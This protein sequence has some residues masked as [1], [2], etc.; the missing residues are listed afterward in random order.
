MRRHLCTISVLVAA[1]GIAG[2]GSHRPENA[3]AA[4]DR[5]RQPAPDGEPVYEANLTVQQDGSHGPEAC[6]VSTLMMPPSCGGLPIVGW[7]WDEVDGEQTFGPAT[8][9]SYHLT[10][11]YDDGVF[12]LTEP[13]GPPELD[14]VGTDVAI[15]PACDN[16]EVVDPTQS[17]V[18]WGTVD[19]S[20]PDLVATWVD[21]RP[22]G[23]TDGP[24]TANVV[25][26]RSAGPTAAACASSSGRH[27]PWTSC[28]GSRTRSSTPTRSPTTTCPSR[29][30]PALSSTPSG[31][32]S[33]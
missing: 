17:I 29:P 1:L 21:D 7:D 3:G 15:P 22:P 28:A 4:R 12:T 13:A 33:G 14:A 11:R 8:W 9:G 16:P 6:V 25:V 26:L 18:R 2:C 30:A 5:A 23:V 24:F 31:W 10:G 19:V 32:R 20:G 27:T